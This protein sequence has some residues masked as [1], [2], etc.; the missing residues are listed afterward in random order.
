MIAHKYRFHGHGSLKYVYRHGHGA[1]TRHLGVRAIKNPHR[2]HSR[3][4]VIVSKKVFKQAAKRNRIRR[5]LFEVICGRFGDI[6]GAHDVSFTVFSGDV[7]LLPSQQLRDEVEHVMKNV[8]LFH[9]H[10]DESIDD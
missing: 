7:L 9:H 2:A 3:I 8:G 1:R 5:R 6:N 10:Q 4:A